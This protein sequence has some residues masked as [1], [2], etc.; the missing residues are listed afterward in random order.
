MACVH[1][2]RAGG[3]SDEKGKVYSQE[4]CGGPHIENTKE[5]LILELN[6]NH[7]LIQKINDIIINKN[8]YH[9]DNVIDYIYIS[10]LINSNLYSIIDLQQQEINTILTTNLSLLINSNNDTILDEPGF[11]EDNIIDA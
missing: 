11:E 9:L 4:L 2:E 3:E 6:P 1:I 8:T 10:L 5:L 7:H